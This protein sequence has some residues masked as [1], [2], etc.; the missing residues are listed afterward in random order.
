MSEIAPACEEA[1]VAAL[2]EANATGDPIELIGRGSKRAF[3]R[4]VQ[5][6][7]TLS[8][9]HFTGIALYEPDELVLSAGAATPIAEI[10]AALDRENQM[11]A[12]EPMDLGP[13]LG[14]EAG[15][16]SL[17]G[18]I[19]CNLSGP[20]R[21]KAGA[22]RDHLLGLRAVTGAGALFKSGGRVVKNV[23]GYDLA[24]LAAGSQGTLAALTQLTVKVLPRPEKTRTLL[25][26][27]LSVAQAQGLFVTALGSAYDV[28][29][30][31]HLPA[32]LAAKSGVD[33]VAGLG[34]A[35]TALRLEGPEPS[36]LARQAE[37]TALLRGIAEPREELHAHRSLAF[38]REVRDCLP[39]AGR[40]GATIWR[41]SVP[42]AAAATIVS[43]LAEEEAAFYLDWGGGLIWLGAA[44]GAKP[45]PETIAAVLKRHG[46]HGNLFVAPA[47]EGA[48][49]PA[50]LPADPTLA[51][52]AVRVKEA[53]DPKQLLNP[54]RLYA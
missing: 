5:A 34:G 33:L 14:G 20:R 40:P 30:A 2:E 53:F 16:G 6:S 41:L 8:L 4:P 25:F 47:G 49:L 11:L 38:W 35:V 26:K 7:A 51:S 1:L 12:F 10:E 21:I 17:G 42:P 48:A 43:D 28:S 18:A 15:A 9:R 36:V 19:A 27:G 3:G 31:A 44:A 13:L 46:G 54:G 50:F 45:S 39:L 29:A 24:K 23:T 37:L 22:A 32:A 52:L